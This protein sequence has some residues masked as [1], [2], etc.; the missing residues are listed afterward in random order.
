M[1]L[2]K[3]AMP[4]VAGMDMGPRC[5]LW[6]DGI[7]S[8]LE[9]RL[10][11]AEMIASGKVMSRLPIL[12]DLLSIQCVF[13]DAG[14]EPDLTKRVCLALNGLDSFTPPVAPQTQIKGMMLYNI[15]SGVSWDGQRGQ[16]RG[17]KAA[18]VSFV[19]RGAKGVE[20]TIGFTVDGKIYP[21]ILCN[22]AETIESAVND[23]LTPEDG[24]TELVDGHVRYQPRARL[25]KNYLGFGVSQSRLDEHLKNLRRDPETGDWIDK[26]ENHLGLAKSYA[27]LASMFQSGGKSSGGIKS[28]IGIEA[29]RSEVIG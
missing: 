15:G 4:V 19:A 9:S 10:L 6:A 18:A 12:M 1:S 28:M 29:G 23:F 8:P 25:P 7:S 24:V 20:Q 2:A 27:K 14:G 3:P 22:R 5:W 13:L 26:V 17:I 16:W 11:W 21:L